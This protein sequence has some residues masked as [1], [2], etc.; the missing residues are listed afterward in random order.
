[1]EGSKKIY[2]WDH[3]SERVKALIWLPLFLENTK[4]IVQLA[5]VGMRAQSL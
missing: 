3:E 4:K 2:Q 1:M 5:L